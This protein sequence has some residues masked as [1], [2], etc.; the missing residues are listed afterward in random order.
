MDENFIRDRITQLRLKKQVS[1]YKMSLE[2]GHSKSYI[3]SI[4]SGRSLPSMPEFLY[5][6]KYFGITP[7][8]FFDVENAE[9]ALVQA[10]MQEA[11]S[12]CESDLKLLAD[13][14]KRMNMQ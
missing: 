4:S 13:I 1:E 14:A 3:Q 12:L 8:E 9:P 11:T 2:L 10:L 5:I 6:C 7:R